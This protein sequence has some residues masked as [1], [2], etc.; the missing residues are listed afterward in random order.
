MSEQQQAPEGAEVQDFGTTKVREAK[1]FNPAFMRAF[2]N[3]PYFAPKSVVVAGDPDSELGKSLAGTFLDDGRACLP[4]SAD[5]ERI[6]FGLMTGSTLVKVTEVRKRDGEP[7]LGADGKVVA[8]TFQALVSDGPPEMV[9]LQGHGHIP[10]LDDQP[11]DWFIVVQDGRQRRRAAMRLQE[12]LDWVAGFFNRLRDGSKPTRRNTL[13][14]VHKAVDKALAAGTKTAGRPLTDEERAA[15]VLENWAPLMAELGIVPGDDGSEYA[16]LAGDDLAWLTETV[17]KILVGD[18]KALGEATKRGLFF[19]A[20]SEDAER[21]GVPAGSFCAYPVWLKVA[22]A[23]VNVD[24]TDPS[25]MLSAIA[26]KE[27]QV[28][29]PPSLFAEQVR[30]ITGLK[31]NPHDPD[32]PPL[33]SLDAIVEKLG[34][35][36]STL[37]D[38]NLL[39]DLCPEVLKL[40]DSGEMSITF[41]V[42]RRE[43]PFIT[44]P[45]KQKRQP[46]PFDK[47]RLVL[48]HL[49]DKLASD[50]EDRV[51]FSGEAAVK[52]AK[53]IRDAAAS[54]KLMPVGHEEEADDATAPLAPTKG[55]E[56]PKPPVAEGEKPAKRARYSL[57]VA[58]FR[59]AVDARL[60]ATDAEKPGVESVARLELARAVLLAATGAEPVS[61]LD[62][63]PDVR[64]AVV[65]GLGQP[66][67]PAAPQ[68]SGR[69]LAFDLCEAAIDRMIADAQDKPSVEGLNL[70][71]GAPDAAIATMAQSLLD[72]WAAD[73]QK[74]QSATSLDEYLMSRAMSERSASPAT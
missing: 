52:I 51:R 37:E 13:I 61:V 31:M 27:A 15:V 69:D 22:V 6:A 2:R 20:K 67:A 63:W 35:S 44:W 16:P 19:A 53:G 66:A 17:A 45:D 73:F 26:A 7:V 57:D 40:V 10:P 12:R 55:S 30:R 5:H 50:G 49:L 32:S 24:P 23:G 38:Y 28:K 4:W 9:F 18:E 58:A 8:D 56:K 47:Q 42:G 46:L 70:P 74:D 36:R 21:L 41:A 11:D 14:K 34:K 72:G 29:T 48:S 33:Y 65:A 59:A 43:S 54:G 60:S 64:D 71:S 62:T 39:H 3:A 1:G 25:S 68:R